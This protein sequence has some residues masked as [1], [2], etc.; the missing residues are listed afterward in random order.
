MYRTFILLHPFP[1]DA[2][3]WAPT[4]A[5]LA[6]RGG[7]HAPEF[8]GFGAAPQAQEP[9][10]DGMADAV[11]ERIASVAPGGRAVVC[12]VSMG[13]YVA[14]ALA[15]RHPE[16]VAGLVL[17]GTHARPDDDAA[18]A[19]RRANAERARAGAVA[20]VLGD[21]V[22]RLTAPDADRSARDAVDAIAARAGGAAVAGAL[23]AMAARADR[24]PD[25]PGLDIPARVLW[26]EDDAVVPHEAAVELAGGLP[27]ASLHVVPGAGHLVPMERPAVFLVHALAVAA[28]ALPD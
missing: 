28:E 11:A 10:I 16:R 7:V 13:G 14:L 17:S 26:G 21:V 18:R 19:A 3:F 1:L 2:D 25:L 9:S 20:G 12:G 27:R 15:A 23:E 24:R 22:P 4:A 8:P 6:A 5:S